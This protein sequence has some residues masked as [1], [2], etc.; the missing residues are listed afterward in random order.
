M[1]KKQSRKVTAKVRKTVTAPENTA[2]VVTEAPV[3]EEQKPVYPV[4]TRPTIEKDEAINRYN[5]LMAFKSMGETV[6]QAH[7]FSKKAEVILNLLETFYK[8]G[9]AKHM[10]LIERF[11]ISLFDVFEMMEIY[12]PNYQITGYQYTNGQDEQVLQSLCPNVFVIFSTAKYNERNGKIVISIIDVCMANDER[13]EEQNRFIDNLTKLFTSLFPEATIYNENITTTEE[14]NFYEPVDYVISH[15]GLLTALAT[16]TDELLDFGDEPLIDISTAY[17]SFPN[18]SG[19]ALIDIFNMVNN[20]FNLGEIITEDTRRIVLG[21]TLFYLAEVNGNVN[22][23]N[24]TIKFAY[25]VYIELETEEEEFEGEPDSNEP[26]Q[27]IV[28]GGRKPVMTNDE[29]GE[30]SQSPEAMND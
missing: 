15:S 17:D 2:P 11:N 25:P 6:D 23:D 7:M 28:S 21:N 19:N 10:E 1:A 5:N 29:D 13:N 3:Q 12:L 18:K 9:V 8:V 22:E 26:Q 24:S 27:Q 30:P 4:Y 14:D 16:N 20:T